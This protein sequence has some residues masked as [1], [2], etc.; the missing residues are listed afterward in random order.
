MTEMDISRVLCENCF[1]I[2]KTILDGLFNG[3]L[4]K[5]KHLL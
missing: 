1:N 5:D 3:N 2:T 4:K